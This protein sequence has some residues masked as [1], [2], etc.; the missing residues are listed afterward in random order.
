MKKSGFTLVE[1]LVVVAI[2]S[3]LAVVGFGIFG[4]AQGGA[5]DGRRRIEIDQLAK[6]IESTR[7]A[8]TGN[9]KYSQGGTDYPTG[10]SDPLSGNKYCYEVST[11]SS[12]PP[13]NPPATWTTFT[14]CPTGWLEIGGS[15]FS[16]NP[17]G[18]DADLEETGIKGWK[19]CA[20]MERSGAPFCKS[21][22]LR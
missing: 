1:L 10:L 22:I 11:T 19:V 13:A 7:D 3:I 5:R 15:T 4:G 8:A 2:I 20:G 18:T 9:Y 21:N 17:S 12:E 16:V 14:S 6:N